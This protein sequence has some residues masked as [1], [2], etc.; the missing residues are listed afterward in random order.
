VLAR[1]PLKETSGAATEAE[2][3]AVAIVAAVEEVA[4]ELEE[5]EEIGTTI[6]DP[7]ITT[8]PR[9]NLNTNN[10]NN[11]S[12]PLRTVNLC[13]ACPSLSPHMPNTHSNKL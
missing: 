8:S 3:V 1:H 13:T 5:E 7:S 11:N 4:V 12:S 10:L 2:A 6:V 9:L